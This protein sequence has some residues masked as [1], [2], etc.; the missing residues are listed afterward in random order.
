[1]SLTVYDKKRDFKRTPEPNSAKSAV[2]KGKLTFVVQKHDASRLHYDFRL[3]MEGVLKSWAIPKGPS[4]VAGEKRLAIMVEDHPLPYG[5]F[6]GEIPEG[7]YG[8]GTVEIWDKG[9]YKPGI[10][11]GD[12]EENLLQMLK[13]GDIKF[14][15]NGTYLKG[16]FALFHLKNEEKENEWMMVKKADEFAEEVFDIG[17]IRSLKSKSKTKASERITS[18]PF[19]DPLPKPM[20]AKL[21]SELN[22]NP[23][24][25]FE[26]KLDGYRMMCS[27][28]NGN[29]ALVSRGGNSYTRQFGILLD[30]LKDIEDNLILDG[31]VVVENS[32]EL[33]DFQLLQNYIKTKT[34]NLKYYVFDLLY[35]NGHNIMKIPLMKRRNLLD[36]LFQKYHFAR[37]VKLDYQTGNGKKLFSK[38]SRQGYEGIIA[39]DP[40]SIYMPGKRGDSWLKIKS[41]QK[42]EAVICGYTLP[43]GTRKYF[44]S[45]ILGLNEGGKLKYI[46]NCGTGFN[47]FTLRELYE[48][49]EILR[50]DKCPF[51]NPPVLSGTK[52]KPV[53]IKPRLVASIKFLEWS[54]EDL[55]RLPVFMGLRDDKDPEEVFNEM[56]NI[57]EAVNKVRDSEKEKTVI[58]S[59][60]EVKFTNLTKIYWADEGYTKA[61]LISYYQTIS[62]Y[63]LPYLRERPQSLNRFPNGIKGQSFYHKDMDV[64]QIPKWMKTVKME[65]KTNP[66]GIDYLIC[67]D[68][69]TLVYMI[70]L[71]C[72]EINPW[73]SIYKK[74]DYPTYLMLDLDPGDISFKMVVDTALVIKELCDEIK[75]P[76]YPKTSGATGLHIYF[77]LGGRYDYEQSR[78]FAEIL[79]V[80]VHN[81]LPSV[82][83]LERT[84]SKRNDKV[85][86]DFLQNR[87]G[88]TIVAPY[89]V[90]PRPMATVSTPLYWKEV[91]HRL[92]PEM[93]TI[94]NIEKRLEKTGDLWQPVLKQSISLS[95]ALKAIEKLS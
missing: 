54:K 73:H 40:D 14:S 29:V 10:E 64:N 21:V 18:D 93:F 84:P 47:D 82:T 17:S 35:L 12:P 42:Q 19:P 88:Q 26:M 1:M 67:N 28:K 9:T 22:D 72:I 24:W 4:M 41:I 52:G 50:T 36:A 90:R 94:M 34:G 70:N 5:K 75:I 86:V 61:D 78:T 76:C 85:Y 43:Q 77:P 53:W 58:L 71:G 44:G 65:S 30:D 87:K 45:I 89:S 46:G 20:L 38:L 49:F 69:A 79:A 27:V 32:L 25:I 95:K 51:G 59:G 23:A 80:I 62:K 11:T 7:N 60:K 68:T 63:I 55:M 13:K 2:K 8:A 16:R 31:E 81:R 66:E 37:V 33:S 91:N 74:P 92:S 48:K 56:K 15:L 6:Y 57:S 39:K 3:E 83:S